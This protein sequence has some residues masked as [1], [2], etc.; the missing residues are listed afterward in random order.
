[1]PQAVSEGFAILCGNANPTLAAKV[2]DAAGVALGDALVERFPDG[3]VSV[4]IRAPVRDKDVFIIQSTAPPVNDHLVELLVIIDACRR[5][6]NIGIPIGILAPVE[7]DAKLFFE[8]GFSFV[9]V[10]SEIGL[11]RKATD[12]LRGKFKN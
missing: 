7:A 9:A 11:L 5:A 10:G 8:T 6:K 12:E 4:E 3:E 2:A 1:M